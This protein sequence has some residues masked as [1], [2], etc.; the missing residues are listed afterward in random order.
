MQLLE[1]VDE[2]QMVKK[3]A[4]F[5]E[6]M[7]VAADSRQPHRVVN[8]LQDLAT[9]FHTF[10]NKCRVLDAQQPDLSRAR[11]A[12]VACLQIVLRNGLKLLGISAP[13]RM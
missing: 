11:L 5:P 9:Q 13:E 3:L 12:L 6:L 1:S 2:Q 10:Y 8:Y 4:A 7:V